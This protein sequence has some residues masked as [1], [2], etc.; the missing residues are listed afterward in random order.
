LSQK[1]VETVE[2]F[3]LEL[4]DITKYH[5]KAQ[6]A[7]KLASLMTSKVLSIIIDTDNREEAKGTVSLLIQTF[8]SKKN[9]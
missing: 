5:E 7:L 1:Q 4:A 6:P 3:K 2:D 8:S 9:S